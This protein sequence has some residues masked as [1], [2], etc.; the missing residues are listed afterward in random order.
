MQEFVWR[1]LRFELPDGWELLLY[2]TSAE[3]GRCMF[4]DRYEYRLELNWQTVPGR[5]DFERMVS[6]YAAALHAEPAVQAVD[7]M[8]AGE[9][10]GLVSTSRTAVITRCGRYL[11]GEKTLIELVFIWPE[12]R[13]TTLE[14]R[15]L[16]SFRDVP[17]AA[18]GRRRWRAFGMDLRVDGA[19][20][21]HACKALPGT[22]RMVFQDPK[23]A[24]REERYERLGLVAQ[25]LKGPVAEWLRLR[26]PPTVSVTSEEHCDV[27]GHAVEVI[28]G[29]A[30]V[31]GWRRLL[32]RRAPFTALAWVCPA[33]GRLYCASV[34]GAGWDDLP[35]PLASGLLCPDLAAA[36]ET[37]GET[38]RA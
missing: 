29:D 6:D 27:A 2:T 37:R 11:P 3:R 21:L 35:G 38:G 33:D 7:P 26:L 34:C 1:H 36:R 23:H 31:G 19:L 5:P 12:K 30:P 22:A 24:W 28:R 9:W 16:D 18:D 13:E 10:Q 14:R 32:R 17:L 20:Q 15:I 8:Q 25:W 4:A